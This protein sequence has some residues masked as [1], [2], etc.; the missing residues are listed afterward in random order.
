MKALVIYDSRT[1][2]TEKMA[3][4][5]AEGA[6]SV[7][8]VSVEVKKIGEAFPLSILA[9]A[10]LAFYGSPVI[11]ADVTDG[12]RSFLEHLKRLVEDGRI[13][14]KGKIA[15]VFGSYGFDGAWIMEER[16]K[17]MLENLGYKVYEKV[18]VETADSVRYRPD[19]ALENCRSFGREAAEARGKI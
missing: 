2:N 17:R 8:G 19:R 7:K 9:D 3:R 12:F 5:I 14:M 18:C 15:A 10:D 4:A 13:S 16:M 11:Y 1:G 6:S